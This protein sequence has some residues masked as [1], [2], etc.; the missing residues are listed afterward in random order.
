MARRLIRL[1]SLFMALAGG[2]AVVGCSSDDDD[3]SGFA[4][5]ICAVYAPCCAKAGLAGPQSSCRMMY[6]SVH[7]TDQA[8]ADQCLSDMEAQAQDPKFCD[9]ELDEPESCQKAFPDGSGGTKQP[10]E[11]CSEDEDCAGDAHCDGFGSEPGKCAVFVVVP[12]GAAC[13]GEKKGSGKSWSGDPQNDQITLCNY[14]DGLVCNTGK[15]AKRAAVGGSCSNASDCVDEAYCKS[16]ACV[17]RQTA[18]SACSGFGDECTLDTYCVDS[19]KTCEPR[20]PDGETCTEGDQCLSDYCS[21]G[22]CKHNSGMA[23]LVLMFMC[24]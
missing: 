19:S 9:F 23:G 2:A 13:I 5:R 12:E 10:G 14:N 15:C 21:K 7:P 8:L 3:S 17:A 6:G 18:G 16:G 11:T 4:D 22:V 24:M 1:V 20:R